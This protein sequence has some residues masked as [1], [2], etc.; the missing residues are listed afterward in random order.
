MDLI[1]YLLAAETIRYR[2]LLFLL[3]RRGQHWFRFWNQATVDTVDHQDPMDV[4][5]PIRRQH[6]DRKRATDTTARCSRSFFIMETN[7]VWSSNSDCNNQ[8]QLLFLI[9]GLDTSC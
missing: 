9:C 2:L 3:D 5:A 7:P 1:L 8:I 6:I 4:S